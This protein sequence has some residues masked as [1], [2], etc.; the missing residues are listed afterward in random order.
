[1]S[2]DTRIGTLFYSS[3]T[4]WETTLNAY[5]PNV[6]DKHLISSR[7]RGWHEVETYST[8]TCWNTGENLGLHL[9]T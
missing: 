5:F 1:M 9:H 4:K 7:P 6:D 8:D 3:R 2:R